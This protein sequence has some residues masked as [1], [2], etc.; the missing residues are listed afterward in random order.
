MRRDVGTVENTER[1]LQAA[2]TRQGRTAALGI[3]M[4]THTARRPDQVC[5]ARDLIIRS[6]ASDAETE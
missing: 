5:A 3:R 1:R 4:A 2:A 6:G